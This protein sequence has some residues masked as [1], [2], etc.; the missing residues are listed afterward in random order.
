MRYPKGKRSTKLITI[1]TSTESDAPHFIDGVCLHGRIDELSDELAFEILEMM[2]LLEGCVA[3]TMYFDAPQGRTSLRRQQGPSSVQLR[4]PE[5][6]AG[7]RATRII[8][9]NNKYL[10][11]AD[12]RHEG[13]DFIALFDQPVKNA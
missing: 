10:L 4:N 1:C 8:P 7:W 13:I 12:I 5:N 2:P 3:C 11:L 6:R 9:N